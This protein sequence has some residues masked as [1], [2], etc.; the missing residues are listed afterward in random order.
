MRASM[1]TFGW[2][3][4]LHAGCFLRPFE[5]YNPC[6]SLIYVLKQKHITT[7]ILLSE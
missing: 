1:D 5:G 3:K 2:L 4:A 7:C 6:D